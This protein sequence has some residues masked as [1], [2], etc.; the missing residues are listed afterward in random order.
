MSLERSDWTVAELQQ[1]P[2]DGNRYEIIDGVLY[3]TPSPRA[4][5]QV[6]LGE[7]YTLLKP[8]GKRVGLFVMLSPADVK[9][10]NDTLVQPDLFAFPAPVRMRDFTYDDIQHL[11]LA[12]E[13]L[14][15]STARVDRSIKRRLYQAQGVSE[16]WVVDGDARTVE[17]W[18][19]T[20]TEGELVSGT[21]RWQ[22]RPD[23][24]PLTIDLPALFRDALGE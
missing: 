3:V 18:W 4:V 16:Y 14:S 5:H 6:I 15:P 9:F 10:S 17:R 11:D 13:I 7:L 2:S 1:L 20:S 23:H 19:P 12:I 8:Y 22:P 24:A 21:L